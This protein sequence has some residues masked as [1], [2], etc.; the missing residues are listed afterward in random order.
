MTPIF[1]TET[2][3]HL[4]TALNA[5]IDAAVGIS[6]IDNAGLNKDIQSERITLHSAWMEVIRHQRVSIVFS[7][8]GIEAWLLLTG[9]VQLSEK[10]YKEYHWWSAKKKLHYIVQK[11][12]D[13]CEDIEESPFKDIE[14]LFDARH[15]LVHDHGKELRT[16][17]E[18]EAYIYKANNMRGLFESIKIVK[19]VGEYLESRVPEKLSNLLSSLQSHDYEAWFT[20]ERFTVLP[21]SPF[22]GAEFPTAQQYSTYVRRKLCV[23]PRRLL[24]DEERKTIKA[25]DH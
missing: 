21:P 18:L 14:K 22:A 25:F 9:S 15:E 1:S 17:E 19:L 7:C 13:K 8:F 16:H 11:L 10:K 6:L 12:T 5:S 3:V 20:Y 4:V 24:V 2:H 23:A